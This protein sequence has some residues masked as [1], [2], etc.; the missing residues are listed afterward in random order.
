MFGN[1]GEIDIPYPIRKTLHL[2]EVDTSPLVMHLLFLLFLI[3]YLYK[4]S[5]LEKIFPGIFL[6]FS[7]KKFAKRTEAPFTDQPPGS[8]EGGY[9]HPRGS[10]PAKTVQPPAWQNDRG[11]HLP[12]LNYIHFYPMSYCQ[13]LYMPYS[14][15]FLYL[16]L[17]L[18][19][20][21]RLPDYITYKILLHP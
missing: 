8:W 6:G 20:H 13:S 1:Y 4:V 11:P 18:H 10:P 16:F 12:T 14:Y 21:D 3:S 7:G 2:Y 9:A 19:H 17:L 15:C 5:F